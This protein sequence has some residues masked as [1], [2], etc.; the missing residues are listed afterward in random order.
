MS[1]PF[2]IEVVTHYRHPRS[3]ELFDTPEEARIN[4]DYHLTDAELPEAGYRKRKSGEI[5]QKTDLIRYRNYEI[6][7]SASKELV[8]ALVGDSGWA[9]RRIRKKD[10]LPDFWTKEPSKAER[11]RIAASERAYARSMVRRGFLD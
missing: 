7:E 1:K 2:G 3:E 8:S 10:L 6:N 11:K 5:I 4:Y 9:G